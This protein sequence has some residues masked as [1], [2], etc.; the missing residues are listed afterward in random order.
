MSHLPI[1]TLYAHS[2]QLWKS[3]PTPV[4]DSDFRAV[5]VLRGE[6]NYF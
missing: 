1:V 4:E 6:P 3:H 5:F 2:G